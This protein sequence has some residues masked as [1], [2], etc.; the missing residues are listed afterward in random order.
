MQFPP[1][2]ETILGIYKEKVLVSRITNFL[3]VLL[4]SQYLWIHV[5]V[6]SVTSLCINGLIN[7]YPDVNSHAWNQKVL[8]GGGGA[9]FILFLIFP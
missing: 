2:S 9:I 5:V 6:E 1:A 8:S 3:M 4:L 7:N